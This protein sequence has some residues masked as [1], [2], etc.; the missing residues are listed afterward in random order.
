M[1]SMRPTAHSR[2][3]GCAVAP[4]RMG[5]PFYDERRQLSTSRVIDGTAPN[6]TVQAMID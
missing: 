5:F 2:V 3:A 4:S 1:H 6:K